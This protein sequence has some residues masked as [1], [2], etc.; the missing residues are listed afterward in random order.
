MFLFWSSCR[1]D[2]NYQT[3]TGDLSFSKDTVYLDTVFTNISSSTYGL[4]V[5]NKGNQDISIPTISLENGI[6]SRYRINVDGENGNTFTNTPLYAN[7]SLYIF[8]E[9]TIAISEA[10]TNEILYTD[11]II[12]DTGENEQ[13][14]PLITLVKDAIFLYPKENISVENTDGEKIISNGF[15]LNNDE[16]HFTNK[17]PYVI[18]GYAIIPENENL[19]I[20]AGARVYFHEASGIYAQANSSLIINGSTSADEETLENEVIFEGDH[21]EPEFSDDSGQWEGIW[22]SKE[23][24]NNQITNL[25]L[26]NATNGLYVEGKN[27]ATTTNLTI[28]NSQIYNSAT[29]NMWCNA[30]NITAKNLVIGN[31]GNSSL[32]IN[33]GGNYSFQHCTIANYWTSTY[34]SGTALQ[35]SNYTLL[36]NASFTNCIIDG[37]SSN[38][39]NLIDSSDNAIFNYNF[40]CCMLKTTTDT[41]ENSSKYDIVYINQNADFENTNKNRFNILDTSFAIDKANAENASSIPYDILGNDRTSNPDIGAYQYTPE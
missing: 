10:I 29:Y 8:I 32:Y 30:S 6:D 23:S 31:S 26:K 17:K 25:T 22:L 1:K 16:L 24:S 14:V 20:D 4:K 5:Y 15:I 41:S 39:I 3:S 40:T 21:L 9:T 33:N 18:Y 36:N 19:L 7:D 13:K 27:A 37:N 28:H 35:I 11:A 34:R 38:E 2:F 12:F